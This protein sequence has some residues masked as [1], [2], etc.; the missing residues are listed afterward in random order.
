MRLLDL[1]LKA[2]WYNLIEKGEKK[3][4][5]REVKPYWLK[6]LCFHF[7]DTKDESCSQCMQCLTEG[8]GYMCYPFD[9][10][11]FRYGYTQRTM[12][13]TLES[14]TVGI[15]RKEWG[16]P[17]YEVFILKLGERVNEDEK[18]LS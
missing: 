17:D 1:P 12:L 3:E 15:G 13:F 18:E 9:A 16:A 10:V 6:R 8:E 4:E 7:Q 5:Y 2:E 11:R 14:I